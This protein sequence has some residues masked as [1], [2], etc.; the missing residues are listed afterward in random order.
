[1]KHSQQA[2][3][4]HLVNYAR[5]PVAPGIRIELSVQRLDPAGCTFAAPMESRPATPI[6]VKAATADRR[7][8]DLPPFADY[9]V[10]CVKTQERSK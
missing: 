10:V 9:A 3:Y 4:V 5:E 8:V 6:A 7:V 1:V 2:F